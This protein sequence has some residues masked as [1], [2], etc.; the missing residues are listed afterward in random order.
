MTR[1]NTG[2]CPTFFVTLTI[3][4]ALS[5]CKTAAREPGKS[6]AMSS[7]N[8]NPDGSSSGIVEN[9]F[10][11]PKAKFGKT[12]TQNL[13]T[14][15]SAEELRIQELPR[16]G[17][18][19]TE[20]LTNRL[21]TKL[22]AGTRLEQ[23]VSQTPRMVLIVDCG[24][25]TLKLPEIKAGV[26]WVYPEL[27][28]GFSTEDQ[29]AALIA[30]ELVHYTRSHEEEIEERMNS[31]MPFREEAVNRSRWEQEKEADRLSTRLVANAALDPYAAADVPE[32]VD[33]LMTGAP[34][35]NQGRINFPIDAAEERTFKI[36][37]ELKHSNLR[38]SPQ[39]VGQMPAVK[40][41]LEARL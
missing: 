14:R 40:E 17:C 27:L 7:V 32:L 10:V 13:V 16:G 39:T 21:V 28:K 35:W 29:V 12:I 9:D 30:H 34:G 1:S 37:F 15:R 33:K 8:G 11:I 31:W 25:K 5:G 6:K 22:I 26:I 23:V 19:K 4:A 3:A 18:P 36:Q 24:N 38:Q 2:F 20:S 41:E